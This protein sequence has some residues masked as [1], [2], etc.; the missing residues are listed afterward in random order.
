[1]SENIKSNIQ[2][3]ITQT[4]KSLNFPEINFSLDHPANE[5]HGDY[6]TNVALVLFPKLKE[7]GIGEY[8]KPIDLAQTIIDHFPPN[9]E[10]SS[11]SAAQPGF[12]NFTL[13]PNF[14]LTSVKS[15]IENKY[16]LPLKG[17]KIAVEYTD[18]NPFKEFHIG[19]LYSNI[20]G[21]SVSRI[22]EVNGAVVW[23][24]DFYGDV[25]LHIAK[26]VWG[27][28]QKMNQDNLTLSAVEKLSLKE[29]QNLLGQG[30]ALGVVKYDQDP[31]I[32]SQIEKIN[33]Q[34]YRFSNQDDQDQVIQVYQAGLKWS[35]DYFETYYQRLGTKF[36]GY[37]PESKI[38][39]IGSK[40][41]DQA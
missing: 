32:K 1:M 4:I 2:E 30:Y 40:I 17:K 20:I 34:I 15:I 6:A 38:G 8:Q 25:G 11:V 26:S 36:D 31:Q 14:L 7:Q 12:I 39:Q 13:S 18:P 28:I 22:Y 24:G 23:R 16:P 19:H 5:T 33:S 35:L 27:L 37:Y 21:E 29:R 10:I 3:L 9:K 41:V